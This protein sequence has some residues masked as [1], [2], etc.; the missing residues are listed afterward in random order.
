MA[1]REPDPAKRFARLDQVLDVDRFLTFAAL[2][3]L[4]VHWDG[5]CNA[6]NNYH[7]FH[8]TERNKMV[9]MPHGMDQLF[10]GGHSISSRVTPQLKGAVVRG[11]LTTG[12]GQRRY[13]ERFNQVLTNHFQ[14]AQLNTKVDQIAQRIQATTGL[15]MWDA[16]QFKLGSRNLKSRIS[17]RVDQVT[18]QLAKAEKPVSFSANGTLRLKDWRFKNGTTG[19]ATGLTAMVDGHEV[20]EIRAGGPGSS[21]SWRKTIRLPPG[22][23]EFTGLAKAKGLAPG[24]PSTGVLLRISGERSIEGISKSSN[25]DTVKYEFTTETAGD[26]DLICEFRGPQGAGFFDLSSLKLQRR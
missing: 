10:E 24:V 11:L 9:F 12:E 4:F 6:M 15:G 8:D 13:L 22:R 21:G 16:L 20:L 26:F 14:A 5:Y 18:G 25:W 23:Y 7:V 19:T 1:A 3:V 2:E 17:Q